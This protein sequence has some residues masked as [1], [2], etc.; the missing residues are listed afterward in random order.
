LRVLECSRRAGGRAGEGRV[1]ECSRRAGG[2]AGEGRVLEFSRRAGGRAGGRKGVACKS[3]P[4]SCTG[5][6]LGSCT[7]R[8]HA[9]SPGTTRHARHCGDCRWCELRCAALRCAVGRA[10][11]VHALQPVVSC[12]RLAT[13]RLVRSRVLN[14]NP[15]LGRSLTATSRQLS[16]RAQARV[17]RRGGTAGA[18]R[19]ADHGR[20][21]VPRAHVAAGTRPRLPVS[22]K[23]AQAGGSEH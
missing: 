4:R 12:A 16:A 3:A 20:P 6:P 5:W 18:R 7:A 1:L 19:W 15:P 17:R 23:A 14:L 10:G 22:L 13:C 2:R 21:R 8:H 9:A 11:A